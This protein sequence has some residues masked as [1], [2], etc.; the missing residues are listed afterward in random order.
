MNFL[1]CSYCA[2]YRNSI[3]LYDNHLNYVFSYQ[4]PDCIDIVS[5]IFHDNEF[6][7]IYRKQ[8]FPIIQNNILEQFNVEL[9]DLLSLNDINVD[10][11]TA[12]FE[13][14]LYSFN[15]QR[16]LLREVKKILIYTVLN[17]NNAH[18]NL[19]ISIFLIS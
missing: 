17:S 4:H 16:K 1:F 8:F 14:L 12:I 7:C 2:L 5:F 11:H 15:E 13:D 18:V 6:Y 19:T 9:K 3:D 10:V